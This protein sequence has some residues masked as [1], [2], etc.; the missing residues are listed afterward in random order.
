LMMKK[1]FSFYLS[2]SAGIFL[3]IILYIVMTKLLSRV[4]MN[5]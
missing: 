1:G 2:L 3:T 5:L 4:G